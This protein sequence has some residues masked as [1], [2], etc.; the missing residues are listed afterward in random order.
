MSMF[1]AK[2]GRLFREK[3]SCRHVA[4]LTPSP[5]RPKRQ[6]FLCFS[7]FICDQIDHSQWSFLRQGMFL[8]GRGKKS[9]PFWIALPV[10][11]KKYCEHH[12]VAKQGLHGDPDTQQDS[13][14]TI[15]GEDSRCIEK[16]LWHLQDLCA[17]MS[18]S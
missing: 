13:K 9:R 15:P 11:Q 4:I 2:M 5:I 6:I 10:R 12:K 17:Y 8:D 3:V 16:P 14:W 1:L 7:T 18:K